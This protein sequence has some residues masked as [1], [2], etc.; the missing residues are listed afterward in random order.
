MVILDVLSDYDKDICRSV[1][2][3]TIILIIPEWWIEQN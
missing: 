2:T 3:K 1:Y